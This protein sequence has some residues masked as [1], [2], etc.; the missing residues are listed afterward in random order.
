MSVTMSCYS[1]ESVVC[2][3]PMFKHVQHAVILRMFDSQRDIAHLFGLCAHTIIQTNEGFRLCHKTGISKPPQ[4]LVHAYKAAC[5]YTSGLGA[6]LILE[7]DAEFMLHDADAFA[8]VDDFIHKHECSYTLGSMGPM[9]LHSGSHYAIRLQWAAHAIVWSHGLRERL[10]ETDFGE[11][12]VHID[13]HFLTHQE[14]FTYSR[15]LVVQRF[16]GTANRR[17]WCK[18][19]SGSVWSDIADAVYLAVTK[20]CIR[21]WKLDTSTESWDLVYK[22]NKGATFRLWFGLRPHLCSLAAAI[23]LIAMIVIAA[24]YTKSRRHKY[25]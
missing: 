17:N 18:R 2:S 7:D 21:H 19:C 9:V 4:D 15:P 23:G 10:I 25:E 16:P 8:D 1:Y 5:R 24:C 3:E 12:V 22:A 20:R 6:V 14:I 11:R 13:G